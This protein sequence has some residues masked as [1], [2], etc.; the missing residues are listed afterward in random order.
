MA[1]AQPDNYGIGTTATRVGATDN[2][3]VSTGTS[4]TSGSSSGSSTGTATT[5]G[6]TSST[7]QN[8]TASQQAQLQQL[9]AM[10]MNGGTPAMQAS[11]AARSAETQQVAGI[12]EGF[13][14]ENAFADAQGLIAQQS[15]RTLEAL[16]PSIN[17]AAEDAGSSGGALRALLL[18]DAGNKAAES[19]S[20]LGVKTASDYGGIQANLSQVLERLTQADPTAINALVQAFGVLKGATVST[21]GTTSGTTT[22]SKTQVGNTS[23]TT[24][25][26][27]N[28]STDYAPFATSSNATGGGEAVSFGGDASQ[29]SNEILSQLSTNRAFA[30]LFF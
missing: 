14:K 6:T 20:A 27:D 8:M 21:T 2:R 17:G 29:F 11:A 24:N 9:I 7:T 3:S 15:R 13:S 23:S 10:L 4:G 30:D 16:L 19:A 12:R 28:K 26:S 5:Q 18:Q 22:E 1:T 25:S